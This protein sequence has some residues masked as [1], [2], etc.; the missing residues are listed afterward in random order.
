MEVHGTLTGDMK[1]VNARQLLRLGLLLPPLVG[2][3][4]WAQ[5]QND[6]K[7]EAQEQEPEKQEVREVLEDALEEHRPWW[8]PKERRDSREK[9][10]PD[11]AFKLQ[12]EED[13]KL[14]LDE[15]VL[16]IRRSY[17][18]RVVR[19]T[20]TEDGFV[21]RLLLDGGRLRTLHV[22]PDGRVVRAHVDER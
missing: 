2:A 15:V 13:A 9:L 4:V 21:V 12:V 17:E 8:M 22:S 10:L 7:Q 5:E 19:A 1:G 20:E 14:S 3:S 6:Q 11:S 16:Q 18:G